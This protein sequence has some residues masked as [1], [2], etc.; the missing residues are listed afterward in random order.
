MSFL[1]FREIDVGAASGAAPLG[2][3]E[4]VLFLAVFAVIFS[5][6]R[7]A[8]VLWMRPLRAASCGAWCCPG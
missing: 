8:G 6:G 1:Y 3:V 7:A 2:A 5:A 4:V